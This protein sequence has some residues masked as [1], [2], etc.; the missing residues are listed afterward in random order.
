MCQAV[1]VGKEFTL[2]LKCVKLR[3]GFTLGTGRTFDL[4]LNNCS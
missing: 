2:Y 4:C 3:K 1:S